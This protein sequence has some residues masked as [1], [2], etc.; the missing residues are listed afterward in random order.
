MTKT[1]TRRKPEPVCMAEMTFCSLV[2]SG[3]PP[4]SMLLAV[5][6]ARFTIV[7]CRS[8]NGAIEK[9]SPSSQ[10]SALPHAHPVSPRPC[11]RGT[12]QTKTDLAGLK[13]HSSVAQRGCDGSPQGEIAHKPAPSLDIYPL[14]RRMALATVQ[15]PRMSPALCRN[16]RVRRT[17]SSDIVKGGVV[18]ACRGAEEARRS[19]WSMLF[20]RILGVEGLRAV[21]MAN[22]R[23][24]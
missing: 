24:R 22:F 18:I 14:A 21:C 12:R 23:P 13:L 10:D 1:V 19:L 6:E 8:Y 11:C 16:F 9:I 5:P 2:A 15:L 17:M 3:C 7:A 20:S 4:F